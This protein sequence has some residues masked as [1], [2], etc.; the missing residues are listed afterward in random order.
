LPRPPP[1]RGLVGLAA[2]AALAASPAG[3]ALAQEQVRPF[4]VPAGPLVAALLDFALQADLSISAGAARR[5][6]P[7]SRPV[8][9]RMTAREA[10]E[11]M[12]AGSGCA[13]RF[14]SGGDVIVV[15]APPPPG[16]P[17]APPAPPR[18]AFAPRPQSVAELLVTAAR[19][20]ALVQRAPYAVSA[21]P[22]ERLQASG[23]Y[24]LNEAA[25]LAAS[26]GMTD[27]GPGRDKIFIRGLADSPLAGTAQST[28]A[29]YLDGS[30]LTYN[31]P[32][33]DLRLVDVQRVEVLRG[34]QGALYG[35]GAIGGIVHIVTNRPDV[36]AFSAAV[37][38]GAWGSVRGGPGADADAVVNLPLVKGRLALRAAGWDEHQGGYIDDP[39]LGL[40]DVNT[41]DRRGLRAALGWRP[42]A[43]WAV[44]A[45]VTRQTI[46]SADTHYVQ[47]GFGDWGRG[48]LVR[49]PHDTD[50]LAVAV[51]LETR[52]S[53]G[54]LSATSTVLRHRFDSRYDASLALPLFAPALGVQPAPFDERNA[55]ELLVNE[56]TAASPEGRRLRWLAGLFQ[57]VG[58]ND[59]ASALTALGGAP[60]VVYS[61]QRYDIVRELAAYGQLSY[62][63]TGRLTLNLGG[64]WFHNSVKTRSAV[65]DPL[66]G[67]SAAFEGKTSGGG[68]APQASL[69]YAPAS[70]LTVY[71][72]ASE[73]Y[74]PGGFNTAAPPD[75]T[76][77]EADGF[78]PQRRYGGDELWS[79][80]AGAK[81]ALWDG[82]AQLRTA[83]FYMSWKGVQSAQL[84]PDGLV[85]VANIGDGRDIGW[86]VE[87]DLEPWPALRLQ[88]NATVADPELTRPAPGFTGR[89]N[90]LPGAPRF[91]AGA[92]A[93]YTRPLGADL[94]LRLDASYAYV[95]PS[96]LT[97]DERTSREM[98][99]YA[100]ARL[101]ASLVTRRWTATAFVQGPLGTSGDTFALGDPFSY[102]LVRQATPARPATFGLRLAVSTR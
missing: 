41:T 101:A 72:Q 54:Q 26:V 7:L 21:V 5:C 36:D 70:D 51:N 95:G 35:A 6:G 85:Y 45:T 28:V 50:F 14:T 29:I 60:A 16:P 92:L 82:R 55:A 27:L 22:A 69:R 39:G 62:D 44:T 73:G 30:R 98:G 74:R 3:V 34:P 2:A 59:Q 43:A 89:A 99:D 20:S 49:E 68:F 32:D 78:Q 77:Q 37:N 66:A 23:A 57:S 94:A 79:Y 15:S 61:E 25:P 38:A 1:T 42:A 11:A 84:L 90:G 63:L 81:L 18:P 83:G 80:E 100:T 76:F 64:R 75:Q 102:R 93:S 96:H 86:E 31:A 13:F 24:D 87:A 17:P 48:N 71:V 91:Q 4:D 58:D 12:L 9:G 8:R 53:W 88:A 46:D 97:L 52:Q 65:T 67:Q 40:H 33:P 19:R 56:V 10:L 47:R